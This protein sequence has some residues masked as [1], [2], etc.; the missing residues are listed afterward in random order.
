MEPGGWG[1]NGEKSTISHLGIDPLHRRLPLLVAIHA[2]VLEHARAP[3]F[4]PRRDARPGVGVRVADAGDAFVVEEE[5]R[6]RFPFLRSVEAGG[7]QGGEFA[8]ELVEVEFERLHGVEEVGIEAFVGVG[9]VRFEPET[10]CH[11]SLVFGREDGFVFFAD[12]RDD[13]LGALDQFRREVFAHAFGDEFFVVDV[14]AG[15]DEF[16]EGFAESDE[17][18]P[19]DGRL[20][21]V[22]V[23]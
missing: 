13:R 2:P 18:P 15:A 8:E 11:E 1:E 5:G 9:L 21:A 17:V 19:D 10:C 3:C 12:G 4:E 6:G 23:A 7:A 14:R 22:G 20:V 16:A